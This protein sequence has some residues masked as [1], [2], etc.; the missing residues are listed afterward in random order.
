VRST[1]KHPVGVD[2]Q[3]KKGLNTSMFNKVYG[4]IGLGLM[5]G[6]LAKA[7]RALLS[8]SAF[9]TAPAAPGFY[10]GTILASDKDSFTL[11]EAAERGIID[12][13][14]SQEDTAE[15]LGR[16]DIVFI[17]LYPKDT[18]EFLKKHKNDFKSGAII[19][20]ISGV[21]NEILNSLNDFLRNDIDFIAGHP[22]AGS[23]KEGFTNSNKNIFNGRNY[24]LMPLPSNKKENLI[25]FK[26]LMHR[27]GFERITETD[28]KTHDIKTAFTSQLCHVIAAALVKC[29]PDTG[30]TAFGGGSFEDLTRIAMINAPL[31]SELF[32]ENKK[33]ILEH[34]ESFEENLLKLKNYIQNDNLSSLCIFLEEVRKKRISMSLKETGITGKK[35]NS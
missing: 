16:C 20:E 34:I 27:I 18:L 6:S 30:I 5:G 2:K 29:A 3:Q 15:M 26:K 11:K 31:W 8:E 28:Y 1:I 10:G 25:F 14:Y 33:N 9:S 32:L 22:M 17:C 12:E 23:E 35:E 19:S 7:I 24:I 4:F 21:K 13:A